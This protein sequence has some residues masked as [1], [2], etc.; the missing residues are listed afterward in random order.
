MTDTTDKTDPAV[1]IVE[2]TKD[3]PGGV[4][5]L[6]GI[7]FDV[8]A[9]ELTSLIGPSGCGKTTT[10]KI[11]AGLI[12]ATS[13]EVIVEGRPVTGPGPE[14]AFVF[15]D[16]ALLPWA[17]VLRNAAFGLELRGVPKAEREATAR[18]Y[19]AK[20]NL[21]GFEHHYPHQLSGGMRQ[22]VGLARALAVD[23][24]IL[25]MDE[26]FASVDEQIRRT[27]QEDLLRLL[28][29]ERKTVLFVTH[30][31]EEAVYVSDQI[32]I[33]TR[34]PGRVSSVVR[35]QIARDGSSDEVRR[36]QGY[37]DAVEEIWGE[38]RAYVEEDMRAPTESAS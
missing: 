38:L 17:T 28:S 14:R 27:F 18:E 32:V 1:R 3:Y 33:L 34:G 22:R 7:T 9:G 4:R 10:L 24:D 5:A 16:F 13:G 12:P 8:P 15:Q 11:V 36:S 21:S 30:S 2:I 25:L 37:L 20:T 6:E 19:I 29:E 23:A 26:P 31:I 35:P